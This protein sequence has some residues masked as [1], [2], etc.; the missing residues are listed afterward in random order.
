[1]KEIYN[2]GIIGPGRIAHKFT[3]GLQSLS[4]ARLYSVASRSKDRAESFC[5]EYGFEKYFNSYE[6]MVN[7]PNL[8]IVYIATTNNVHYDHTLLC[9]KAGKAVLCEKP[10]ALNSGQVYEMIDC[11]REKKV[12]LME[13]LCT[14][15]MPNML[16]LKK[17]IELGVI[18]KPIMLQCDFGFIKPFDPLDRV[19]DQA[20]G[21]GSVPDIGIYPVFTSLFLFGKPI[22]IKV[23]SVAAPSGTDW[24]TSVLLS[25]KDGEISML[26]SSF[27]TQ[28]NNEARVYGTK[29]QLKIP[30]QFSRGN[31]LKFVNPDGLE[32]DIPVN[33]ISNGYNY[34]AAEVM[35]CLDNGLIESPSMSHSF[36]VQLIEV[37]DE[38]S[39]KCNE[40]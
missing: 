15:F 4:R 22:K 7:D 11:S 33:M 10:L 17:Q 24:T 36:S 20:C 16:M 27:Q 26:S 5:N 30:R 31:N 14:R 9:L 18:G 39:S 3:T 34:E 13:A 8:D 25:H 32:T 23:V 19:Y 37:L 1:M 35:S 21:G 2:W 29:G 12:F 6:D 28:L 38:I 40:L